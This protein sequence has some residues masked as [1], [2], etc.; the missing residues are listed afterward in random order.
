MSSES[1]N[2]L[3]SVLALGQAKRVAKSIL[4]TEQGRV[5]E[6]LRQDTEVE[7]KAARLVEIIEGNQE[8]KAVRRRDEERGKTPSTTPTA[9]AIPPIV[10][11]IIL[12][13]AAKV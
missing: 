2:L 3:E 7:E 10:W 13:L 6:V 11:L 1:T 12:I 9:L 8:Y 4:S 5:T